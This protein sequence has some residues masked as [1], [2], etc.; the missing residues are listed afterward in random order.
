M[1][2]DILLKLELTLLKL[3]SVEVLS[4]LQE[5]KK[6]SVLDKLQL[7]LMLQMQEMSILKRLVYMY[8]SVVMVE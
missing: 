5:S 6:E 8:Q 4:V 3:E 2:L 7:S 1:D